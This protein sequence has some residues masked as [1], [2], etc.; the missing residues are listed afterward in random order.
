MLTRLVKKTTFKVVFIGKP[1]GCVVDLAAK[2]AD[3]LKLHLL[4]SSELIKKA[5]GGTT[6]TGKA[7]KAQ[8]ESYNKCFKDIDV[9]KL[10]TSHIEQVDQL[11]DP[12]N[13]SDMRGYVLVNFPQNANQSKLLQ[14]SG[15]L[16]KRVFV[17]EEDDSYC[18]ENFKNWSNNSTLSKQD[19]D[20]K[21]ESQLKN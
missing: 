9:A 2:I 11:W 13:E 16:P 18:R 14:F 6:E 3:L 19:L 7:L 17:I 10:V 4:N 1:G 21:F 15:N 8:L 12:K 20:K 5:I